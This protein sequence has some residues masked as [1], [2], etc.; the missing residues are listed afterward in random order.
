MQPST[1]EQAKAHF[2]AGL[3]HF[4]AGRYAEAERDFAASVA[5]VP[6]RSSSLTNL[7]ATRLR[8]GRIELAAADLRAAVEAEPGNA[9]A[10]GHLG[11]ALAELGHADDALAAL[12]ESL[13][14]NPNVGAPWM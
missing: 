13:R 2:L 11:S 8:L 9:E 7:G 12:T 4:E 6:G 14:L 10:L 5:L 3:G 1:F